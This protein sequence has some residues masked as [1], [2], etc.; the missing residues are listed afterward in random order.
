MTAFPSSP[1]DGQVYT[2]GPRSWTWSDA[3]VAWSMNRG[4]PTG[5]TGTSGPQGP[6]GVLL[7]A[8]TVDTYFGDGITTIFTLSLTPISVYNMIVNL[9]GLVQTANINYTI[10]GN[11]LIFGD[12]PINN[13]T[14]DVVHFITGS[15]ITGP[16]GTGGVTGPTGPRSI[17]AGPTG[18]MG[19]PGMQRVPVPLTSVGQLGDIDGMLAF[20]ASYFYYCSGSYDVISNIWKRTAWN[21]DTW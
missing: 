20:N 2:L 21:G 8:L 14:I 17:T 4:G 3:I 13:S 12:A 10:S 6:A 15:P 9:D 16:A 11:T 7:T 18:P 1:Y 5:P 19:S